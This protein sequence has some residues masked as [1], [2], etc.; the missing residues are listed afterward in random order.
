MAFCKV[1]N[2]KAQS[3]SYCILYMNRRIRYHMTYINIKSDEV[4]DIWYCPCWGENILTWDKQLDNNFCLPVYLFVPLNIHY[5]QWPHSILHLRSCA[6]NVSYYLYSHGH[7]SGSYSSRRYEVLLCMQL[8]YLRQ[9]GI[10]LG[11]G[12]NSGAAGR[13]G[14]C[15]LSN[16][17]WSTEYWSQY[18]DAIESTMAGN[19]WI[20]RTKGQ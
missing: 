17:F 3:F 5:Q 6:C 1:Y 2:G 11:T 7:L 10:E 15:M 8:L 12:L 9:Q 16:G 14:R 19:R 13:S 18:K 20:L 4:C